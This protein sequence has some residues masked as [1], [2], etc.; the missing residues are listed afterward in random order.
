MR[1]N[2]RHFLSA[3]GLGAAGIAASGRKALGSSAV[4]KRLIVLS[5]SHGTVYDGW[6]MRPGGLR[7]DRPWA[8]SLSGLGPSDFSRA[9]EPLHAHRSRLQVLDGLEYA[10][11]NRER[12]AYIYD[13]NA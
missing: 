11:L 12:L 4:P 13:F 5:T 8:A 2:R 9:L 10:I 7:D 3:L 6:K 1:I